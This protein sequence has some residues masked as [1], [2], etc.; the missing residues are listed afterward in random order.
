MIGAISNSFT[1]LTTIV[2][3]LNLT[4]LLA[5][6]FLKNIIWLPWCIDANFALLSFTQSKVVNIL[7]KSTIFTLLVMYLE[8]T[9]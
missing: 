3:I 7:N 6:F 1:N 8:E 5:L 9:T 2:F 4:N